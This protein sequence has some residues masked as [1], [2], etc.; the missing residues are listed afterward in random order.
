MRSAPN[1][2]LPAELA[3]HGLF[4]RGSFELGVSDELSGTIVLVGSAGD[5]WWQPFQNW[6][7]TRTGPVAN[8]LD[9]WTREIVGA[10]ADSHGAHLV[11]PNDRPYAPFQ[12]WA[13]RAEGLR[14]SPL[15]IL[16]HPEYGLWHSY[17]AALLFD[18]R[19]PEKVNQ[20]AEKPIHACDLCAGK[21]CLN[22]CPAGAHSRCGFDHAA[23]L[24]HVHGDKGEAC[25]V[26][27]CFSRNACPVG[28][29]WR[30]QREA[31]AFLQRAFA[32]S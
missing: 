17:R 8:P 2:E 3:S 25:L 12:Q 26:D 23:C 30:Y 7:S 6:L 1:E 31:Q 13:M 22:A 15:G 32:G 28:A 5:S 18:A 4:V 21:P 19:L 27:G 11:M 20:Q 9:S 14:A 10:L 24:S 16:M 29:D